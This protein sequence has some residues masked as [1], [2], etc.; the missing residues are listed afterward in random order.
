MSEYYKLGLDLVFS[1][2]NLG[3]IGF[4]VIYIVKGGYKVRSGLR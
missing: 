4:R 2:K 1:E 3:L